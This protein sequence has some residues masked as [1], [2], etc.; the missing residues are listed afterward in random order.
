M[1]VGGALG[2]I[3]KQE[4]GLFVPLCPDAE[5]MNTMG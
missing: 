1:T 3:A 5:Q 4:P 2:D